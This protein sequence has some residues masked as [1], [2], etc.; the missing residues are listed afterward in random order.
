MD[1]RKRRILKTGGILTVVAVIGAYTA[2]TSYAQHC[3]AMPSSAPTKTR[4]TQQATPAGPVKAAVSL[5]VIHAKQIP[6]VQEAVERALQHLEAGRQQQAI[7]ELRQVQASL[8]SLHEALGK[9]IGPQIVND[10]CP[11]MGGK[12]DPERVP[13]ALTRVHGRDKVAFCCGGCPDQWNRLSY[14][15]KT[16]R[17]KEV[18]IRQD[19][20][21]GIP[22]Q[23]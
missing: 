1:A 4:A 2:A 11:I 18:A 20:P 13:A 5:Q 8:E 23:P 15:E 22:N 16:A 21:Q 9:H 17:L 14:A 3:P 10:R 19:Q 12:I 7:E 6:A